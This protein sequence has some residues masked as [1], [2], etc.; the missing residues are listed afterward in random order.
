MDLRREQIRGVPRLP[1]W[2][3]GFLCVYGIGWFINDLSGGDH[4]LPR[5]VDAPLAALMAVTMGASFVKVWRER[6]ER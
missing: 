3:S 6:S 2:A 1:L 5:V 4:G